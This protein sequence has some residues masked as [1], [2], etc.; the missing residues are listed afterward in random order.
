MTNYTGI[1]LE[2]VSALG[3]TI[4][5]NNT[6]HWNGSRQFFYPVGQHIREY[7]LETNQLQFLFSERFG[8]NCTE[9]IEICDLAVTSNGQFIAISEVYRPNHAILSIYD[10]ETQVA[11]VHLRHDEVEKF[12]SLTLSSDGSFIAALGIGSQNCRIF[13]WKM[14]RQVPPLTIIPVSNTTTS[15]CFDPQNHYRLVIFG[16]PGI[17]S[18]LINTIDKT[19]KEIETDQTFEKYVFVPSVNGLLLASFQT[20]LYIIMNDTIVE[21][22]QPLQKEN[23]DFLRSVRNYVFIISG[24]NIHMY[25]ANP[26]PPYLA[27]VGLIDLSISTINDFSPSPDGDLAVVLYDNSYSG[28]LDINVAMKIIKQNNETKE[29]ESKELEQEQEAELNSFMETQAELDMDLQSSIVN[30]KEMQQFIGLFTPLP[31]RY[32]I[33]PIVAV[34][35]CPRKPLLATCG[36]QDRTL[37]VWNL[38]KK[39]VIASEKLPEPVNSC[40]F[41]PSGDLLAVGTSEKLLLYSLT[42]DSLVLRTKWDSFSCT[43]VSF[44]NGGHLLAAGSLIIKVISTYNAK[45]VTSLRGHNLTIKSITWAPND[46]FFISSGIDGNVYKWSAKTWDRE[47]QVSLP[48]QCLSALLTESSTTVHDSIENEGSSITNTNYNVLVATANSTIYDMEL[49]CERMPNQRRII[50]AIDMPVSFSMISGDT[51]GNL[52]VIPYPLLPSGEENPFHIGVEVSVHTQAVHCIVS[53]TDGQTLIS[54]SEDSSVFIFN[55]VQPHQIVIAAPV[56]M[57]YQHKDQ[58][59]LI[60]RDAFEEKKDNLSRLRE[61]MNLHRS[62]YQCA[63]TRLKEK[64]S[65]EIAQIK[66]QWQ[67]TLCSLQNHLHALVN[68]KTEQEKKATEMIAESDSQ[69]FAKI[70]KVKELYEQK[71]SEETQKSGELVKEKIRVQ[72]E[73]EKKLHQMTEEYKK[74]LLDHKEEAQ[75]QLELQATDNTSAEREYKQ[76]QRLQ[77][78]EINVLRQEHEREMEEY[79][80]KLEQNIIDLNSKIERARTKLVSDQDTHES[81]VEHK[82]RLLAEKEKIIQE[83]AILLRKQ[84]TCSEQITVLKNEL[85][86]RNERVE[87]QTSNLLAFKSKNDE[88]TKWRNVMDFRLKELKKQTEPKNK[89]IEVL[90][91]KIDKNEISLR[92]MKKSTQK[93]QDKLDKMEAEI[94]GLYNEIIKAENAI[95]KCEMKINLFKNKVHSVYTE[96]DPEFWGDELV[97]MFKEFVTDTKVDNEDKALLDS[98]YEFDRQKVSLAQKVI[99][100]RVKVE[101]DSETSGNTYLKQ[102]R[103]NEN[104]ISDLQKLREEN[105]K[106]RSELRFLQTSINSLMKQ[107]ARESKPLETKMKSM[108]KSANISNIICQPGQQLGIKRTAKSGIPVVIEQFL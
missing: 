99:D 50:T 8:K 83:R 18:I 27:Y 85:M 52:L 14:G 60:E 79:R 78:E 57:A 59:F 65:N 1:R 21:T 46:S 6:I 32:H 104:F 88:L 68:Q 84:K 61:M 101:N 2:P 107:C 30:A 98:L 76:V 92:S 34:A 22:I 66:N 108:I 91:K 54:G 7:Q 97:K 49:Q 38:A 58:N 90:R 96:I 56:S 10:S 45:V 100:L 43:C 71:L 39:T 35:T 19:M 73:F 105:S 48:T 44:S 95:T 72:C 16:S 87:R 23:I 69:H 24:S 17:R 25:K 86:A 51:R 102:I 36:G 55:I 28:L 9:V 42:F 3:I 29:N 82:N 53:S 81:Q 89:E 94:N 20:F 67:M 75:I 77:V 47:T 26:D 64:Q 70:R 62:Q 12:V 74:K 15:I 103:R 63:Q 5:K 80:Q 4:L 33:G 40:S 106:L 41:H 13:L 31:I 93:D 11:H 37:L